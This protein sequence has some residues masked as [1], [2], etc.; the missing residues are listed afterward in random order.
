MQHDTRRHR[1]R[2]RVR[3]AGPR[4]RARSE[5]RAAV[6][7]G[8]IVAY[9]PSG[10]IDFGLLQERRG[11]WRK[12]TGAPAGRAEFDDVP[13]R[14]LAFDLLQPGDHVLLDQPYQRRRELLAELPMPDRHRVTITSAYTFEESAP[15][16]I[17][18]QALLARIGRD[19]G[20]GLLWIRFAPD[21]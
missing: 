6:L 7:D 15:D 20:E 17:T 4:A 2:R 5:G 10:Q 13:V 8:E 1:F 16:R 12:N 19:G 9:N 18:P 11:R 21:R 14:Y 3:R